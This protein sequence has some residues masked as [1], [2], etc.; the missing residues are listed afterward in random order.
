MRWK[1]RQQSDNVEDR[2]GL[3]GP[4]IVGG[5]LGTLILIILG[6]VFFG[7]PNQFAGVMPA[8]GPAAG[9]PGEQRELTEAEKE[10]GE[11]VSVV[12]KDLEDVWTEEFARHGQTYE[13]PHMELFSGSTRSAC[14]PASAAVGPFY[15]PLDRKV[16]LDTAF[17][18]ELEEKFKAPGNF[19]Q[20]YVVAHEVGHHV[21]NLLGITE[22]VDRLR[23]RASEDEV[24]AA[25][26]RLELQADFLA[27]VWANHAQRTKNILEPGDI[28][29]GIRAA[30]AI[31]DDTLQKESQGYIV[32]EK[33]THGSSE[34][35]ARWFSKG[36][37]TGDMTQGD[38]FAVP[39]SEL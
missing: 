37:A 1:G 32:P 10:Q 19:A 5:G 29:S 18:Q 24:N 36:F 30:L 7:N 15:C 26:V 16:Y 12:L 35:R 33:F 28:E 25:S 38:T 34:Q 31:G 21:Q 3:S 2:R 6:L 14:G 23:G 27:G 11:F 4:A 17:F 8:G 22:Q 20:A 9:Q 13:K 39:A